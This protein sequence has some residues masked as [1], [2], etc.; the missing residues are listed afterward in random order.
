YYANIKMPGLSAEQIQRAYD[1]AFAQWSAVCNID[2]IRVD[3]PGVANIFARS[4]K[5][6]SDGLDDRG[7]TLAWSE[8]PCDVTE[9]MQLD[10][11]FDE[12]E[13]W[14]YEMAIAVICHELG[15]ALGLAHLGKGNLMAPYYDPNVSAPQK[16]DIAAM[17]EL[18]GKRKKPLKSAKNDLTQIQGTI[19]INGRPYMLVPQF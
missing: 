14:S 4:G 7:G 13:D 6:K 15:H 5:G 12:A 11:M 17:V 9:Q 10:Q 1:T 18:Y 8:L 16:G 3:W 2:P 19:M